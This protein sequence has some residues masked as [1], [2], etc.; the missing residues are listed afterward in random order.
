MK[1]EYKYIHFMNIGDIGKTSRWSIHSNRTQ[2]FLGEV[3]W[4]SAWRQYCFFTTMDAVFNDNCMK[5]ILDFIG[6]LS[7]AR[8]GTAKNV[9]T[10]AALCH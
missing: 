7:A 6:Q 9:P 4:Y 3:K 5:D 10:T 8:D 2:A 1:T